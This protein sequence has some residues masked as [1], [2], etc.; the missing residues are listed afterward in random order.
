MEA[1][2]GELGVEPVLFAFG[3]IADVGVSHGR[4]FTGGVLGGVSGGVGAVDDDLGVL[5]GD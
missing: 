1:F 5:V 3:I 4:Q 2:R